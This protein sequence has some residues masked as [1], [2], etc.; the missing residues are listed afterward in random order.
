M[1]NVPVGTFRQPD[2]LEER[3]VLDREHGPG[4]ELTEHDNRSKRRG[5]GEQPGALT[6][7]STTVRDLGRGGRARG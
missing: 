1:P 2:R 5:G 3:G 4:D 7:P 6:W